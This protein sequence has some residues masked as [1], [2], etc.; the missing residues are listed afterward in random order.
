[1]DLWDKMPGTVAKGKMEEKEYTKGIG[2]AGNGKRGG[3]KFGGYQGGAPGESKGGWYQGQCSTYGKINWP[4]VVGM[5]K[6]S[7][8][9]ACVSLLRETVPEVVNRLLG[10]ALVDIAQALIGES[11]LKELERQSLN[12]DTPRYRNV[13][14]ISYNRHGDKSPAG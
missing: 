13:F 3:G 8:W 4:Q 10:F 1:M 2:K 14:C 11:A 5:S 7:L 6:G 12:G 9:S